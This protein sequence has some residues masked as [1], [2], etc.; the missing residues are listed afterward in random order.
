MAMIGRK[1]VNSVEVI[2]YHNHRKNSQANWGSLHELFKAINQ[3]G[4]MVFRRRFNVDKTA[5]WIWEG[6]ERIRKKDGRKDSRPDQ[7]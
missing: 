4:A 3:Q 5:G 6:L 1:W 2:F 7:K